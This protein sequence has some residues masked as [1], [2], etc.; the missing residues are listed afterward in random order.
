MIV[1]TGKNWSIPAFWPILLRFISAPVLAIIYG[2]AYPAFYELRDDPLHILGFGLAHICLVL[3][4]LGV[5]VPRWYNTIIPPDRREEGKL[6]YA[7]NV[8]L[9]G[10]EPR[11]TESMETGEGLAGSEGGESEEKKGQSVM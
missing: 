11:R 4:G 7:P 6:P 8:L 10:E 1:A 5:L 9:D 2:F 3:I